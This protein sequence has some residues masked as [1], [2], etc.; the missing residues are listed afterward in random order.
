VTEI[1]YDVILPGERAAWLIAVA[2]AL[3]R[4]DRPARWIAVI[5]LLGNAA[6]LTVMWVRP[7]EVAV[8]IAGVLAMGVVA[9]RAPRPGVFWAAAFQLI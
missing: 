8:D 9:A 6:M 3:W 1:H 5:Y 7:A 2:F 4:G